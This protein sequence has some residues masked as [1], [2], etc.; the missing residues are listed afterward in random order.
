MMTEHLSQLSK[1]HE[2]LRVHEIFGFFEP[3]SNFKLQKRLKWSIKYYFRDR[4]SARA[5]KTF[6]QVIGLFSN[7]QGKMIDF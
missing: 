4:P 2:N 1:S 7:F 6:C 3:L 5:E